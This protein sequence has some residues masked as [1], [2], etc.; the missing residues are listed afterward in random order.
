MQ[1]EAGFVIDNR[2]SLTVSPEK[3]P[4]KVIFPDVCTHGF[5]FVKFSGT[6]TTVPATPFET[7]NSFVSDTPSPVNVHGA[8]PV[9]VKEES[10]IAGRSFSMTAPDTSLAMVTM[11]AFPGTQPSSHFVSSLHFPPPPSHVQAKPRS[12]TYTS[13][14]PRRHESFF[15]APGDGLSLPV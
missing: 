6:E 3:S 8:D 15:A 4:P 2:N 12:G 13:P 11:A 5:S 9:K 14:L 1:P 10:A 7:A